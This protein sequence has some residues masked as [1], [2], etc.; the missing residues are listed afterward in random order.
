MFVKVFV[1]I[2]SHSCDCCMAGSGRRP[3]HTAEWYQYPRGICALELDWRVWMVG[4]WQ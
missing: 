2:M 4:S 3:L 1:C